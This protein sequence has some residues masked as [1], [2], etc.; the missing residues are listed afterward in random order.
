MAPHYPSIQSFYS[1]SSPMK[2]PARAATASS[3]D[4]T[5]LQRFPSSFRPKPGDG[6]TEE[7]IEAVLSPP[8]A[9]WTPTQEYE[10][11]EIGE[12]EPCPKFVTFS[13]RL[14]NFYDM[15][16]PSKRPMAAKGCLK[17]MVAD[18]T[19]AVTVRIHMN[20]LPLLPGQANA[21]QTGPRVVRRYE[22]PS[23]SWTDRHC[24]DCA[25]VSWRASVT[26]AFNCALV[27]FHLPG[28]GAKLSSRDSR[29]G[30][31][32]YHV[33]EAVRAQR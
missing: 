13:G 28:T 21:W 17:L 16:K 22:I 24:L 6:F 4:P 27:H 23:P 20:T 32:W 1:S 10:E 25:C 33:Q 9:Q 26:C 12:L 5:T 14:V 3:S 19:G 15:V 11:V 7:E 18:D 31:Q 29:E 8:S 30:R 2:N